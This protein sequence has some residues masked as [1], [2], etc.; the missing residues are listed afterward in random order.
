MA[1]QCGTCSTTGIIKLLWG[2]EEGFIL[3]VTYYLAFKRTITIIPGEGHGDTIMQTWKHSKTQCWCYYCAILG[4]K[5]QFLFEK[6]TTF[7]VRVVAS[8]APWD[9]DFKMEIDMQKVY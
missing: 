6:V 9:G 5:Q 2:T 8:W 3:Q 1:V 7:I 4:Y